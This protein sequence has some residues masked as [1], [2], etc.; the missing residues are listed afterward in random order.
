MQETDL[1]EN[2]ETVEAVAWKQLA[3]MVDDGSLSMTLELKEPDESVE[4]ILP[5]RTK[6][7]GVESAL[8]DLVNRMK[9][10]E[11]AANFEFAFISFNDQVTERKDPT[12]VMS[13]STT[14]TFDPTA[15]GTGGT[16]IH[17]GLL[18]AEEIV[19]EF[20]ARHRG[21]ELPV[22]AVVVLMSD[23]EEMHDP[24]LT[25]EI[26][27]R[28]REA[29]NVSVAACLFATKGEPAH[30]DRL[31]ESLVSESRLY[32]RVYN[33]EQLRGFFWD[34]VTATR[35]ALPAAGETGA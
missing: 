35:P 33:T 31:L 28:L 26:G 3:V 22:S 16:A 23:G 17:T 32:Q 7:A 4:G 14:D 24:K 30:G 25:A 27:A 5:V 29:A 13:I 12:P 21:S 10:S 9:A 8:K 15:N 20:F 6:A 19:T 2:L 18:A 1:I 11:K 34:S